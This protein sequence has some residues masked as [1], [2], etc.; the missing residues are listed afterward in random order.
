MLMKTSFRP[1]ATY[2]PVR[3]VPVNAYTAVIDCKAGNVI[4]TA[5]T[6]Q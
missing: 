2:P 3:P 6:T 1:T 4:V 5:N